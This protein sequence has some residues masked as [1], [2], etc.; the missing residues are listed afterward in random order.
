M[1]TRARE[2]FAIADKNSDGSLSHKELKHALQGNDA[3]RAELGAAG[4]KHWK[5]FWTELD[6]D[7]VS[8]LDIWGKTEDQKARRKNDCDAPKGCETHTSCV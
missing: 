3:M 2:I 7:K 8:R 6:A 5:D 1:Q 4:G